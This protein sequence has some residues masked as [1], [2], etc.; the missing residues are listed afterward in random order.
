MPKKRFSNLINYSYFTGVFW[1][2]SIEN[3][4]RLLRSLDYCRYNF[5]LGEDMWIANIVP[6]KLYQVVKLKGMKA[7]DYRFIAGSGSTVR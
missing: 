2:S 1:P 7:V 5:S 3:D 4:N 6:N